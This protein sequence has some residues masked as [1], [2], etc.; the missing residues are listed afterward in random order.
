MSKKQKVRQLNLSAKPILK[1]EGLWSLLKKRTH[2]FWALGLLVFLVYLNSLDNAFVSDDIYWIPQNPSLGDWKFLAGFPNRVGMWAVL[3]LAHQIGGL[4]PFFFRLPNLLAHLG[5]VLVINLLFDLL[6]GRKLAIFVA[7]L[8]A[9]HPILTES[10]SWIAGGSYAQYS[11]LIL[12]SLLFYVL[13]QKNGKRKFY[14][15]SLMFGILAVLFSEQAVVIGGIFF[16][17]EL[18]LGSL[19]KNWSKIL[20]YLG[21]SLAYA[22]LLLSRVGERL[23]GLQ[24]AYYHEPTSYN[25]FVQIPVAVT[26]YLKLI[27]WPKDLTLYHSELFFTYQEYLTRAVLTVLFLGLILLTWRFQKFICFWLAFFVISLASTLTPLAVAW[28]VAER[29]VYLGSLGI[30]AAVGWIFERTNRRKSFEPIL[31]SFFILL[32]TLLSVRTI[33]RNNDWQN[34]DNLWIATAKTSPSSPNTHNNLGDVFARHGELEKAAAE[35]K[36]AIEIKP[37]YADAYHNLANTYQKMAERKNSVEYLELAMKN[38]EEATRYNLNLWQSYQNLGA[39]F[40]EQKDFAKAVENFKRASEINPS[41][42]N[43]KYNLGISYL[44]LGQKE[45]ARQIF[46][47]LLKLDPLNQKLLQILSETD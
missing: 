10:V 34:E 15:L 4:T 27:F 11:F 22:F 33:L 23:T 44:R 37:D 38:Y 6:W 8:F 26:E 7:S 16:L 12:L 39:I 40:F 3:F 14:L 42:F 46:L 18:T 28:V 21:I 43:L 5:S 2:I 19:K 41:N 13:A 47:A 30:L 17:Y 32:I 31:Y 29:Y 35:F 24:T 45:Q 9:V 20:P 36:K 1:E 25:P